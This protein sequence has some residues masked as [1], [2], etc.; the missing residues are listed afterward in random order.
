MR[1]ET[2]RLRQRQ[3]SG[4]LTVGARRTGRRRSRESVRV[5]RWRRLFPSLRQ[6]QL[7]AAAGSSGHGGGG[8]GGSSLQTPG[9]GSSTAPHTPGTWEPGN[10]FRPSGAPSPVQ[11]TS[12]AALPPLASAQSRSGSV[13]A[14]PPI[15]SPVSGCGVGSSSLPSFL[16]LS[17]GPGGGGGGGGGSSSS[18]SSTSPHSPGSGAALCEECRLRSRLALPHSPSPLLLVLRL[19]PPPPSLTPPSAPPPA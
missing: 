11:G 2:L 19:L 6:E 7:Q 15:R 18:S 8:G 12:A 4:G 16:P 3:G 9:S 5:G 14:L 10:R 1:R 17:L 13:R